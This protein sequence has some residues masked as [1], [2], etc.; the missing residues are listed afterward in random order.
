MKKEDVHVKGIDI[1]TEDDFSLGIVLVP[2]H[3]IKV[4]GTVIWHIVC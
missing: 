3:Q 1:Y 2:L 4:K